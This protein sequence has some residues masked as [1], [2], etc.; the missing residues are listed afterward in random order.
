MHG[1]GAGCGKLGGE[2]REPDVN[3]AWRRR[4]QIVRL[5]A[6]I[7]HG[8]NISRRAART[9]ER[10]AAPSAVVPGRREAASP[11]TM[12]TGPFRI[13]SVRVHGPR[14]PSLRIAD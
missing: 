10:V 7:V 2:K 9:Q 13:C 4:E 1:L 14:A 5:N 8:A 6:F 12:N 3:D 11:E